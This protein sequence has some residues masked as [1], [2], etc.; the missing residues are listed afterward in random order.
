MNECVSSEEA[1]PD[2][3]KKSRSRR[4][5]KMSLSTLNCAIFLPNYLQNRKIY[6]ATYLCQSHQESRKPDLKRAVADNKPKRIIAL[7]CV[8]ALAYMYP[9]IF[10]PLFGFKST[11]SEEEIQREK[12]K[13]E[14]AKHRPENMPEWSSPFGPKGG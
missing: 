6:T 13:E 4:P 14:I 7:A 10:R 5:P 8:L 9:M 3:T 12:I 11:S 2:S 1:S